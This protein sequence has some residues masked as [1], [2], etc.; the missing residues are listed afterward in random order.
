MLM[1]VM[2]ASFALKSSMEEK[3]AVA[4][5][6]K[7]ESLYFSGKEEEPQSNDNNDVVSEREKIHVSEKQQKEASTIKPTNIPDAKK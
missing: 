3:R 5:L 6:A 7:G 1:A 2:N 4:S